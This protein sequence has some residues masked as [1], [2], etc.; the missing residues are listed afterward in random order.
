MAVTKNVAIASVVIMYKLFCSV[1]KMA[2]SFSNAEDR[3]R[4]SSKA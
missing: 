4:S 2:L 3:V 1:L